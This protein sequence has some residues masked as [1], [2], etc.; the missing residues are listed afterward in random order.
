[1]TRSGAGAKT[2]SEGVDA[3]VFSEQ[4]RSLY[5]KGNLAVPTALIN[6]AILA[7]ALW[8]S[9]VQRALAAWCV[10]V[11]VV[12][13]A[14]HALSRAYV[15]RSPPPKEASRWAERF[16]AGSLANG[17]VWGAASVVIWVPGGVVEQVLLVFVL[18]ASSPE[19]HRAPPA[20]R[21]RSSRTR[22]RLCRLPSSGSS[23][24]ATGSTWRWGRCSPSS[25]AR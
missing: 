25:P 16:T 24:R 13:L 2:A 6:A 4:V 7:V 18:E 11:V 12:T 17:L 20:T 9:T 19:P 10:A 22:S 21:E 23:W 5:A 15:R 8:T 14:R 1:M 3:L